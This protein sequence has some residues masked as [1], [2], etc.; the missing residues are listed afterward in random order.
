MFTLLLFCQ[1]YSARTDLGISTA[2][3]IALPRGRGIGRNTVKRRFWTPVKVEKI[4]IQRRLTHPGSCRKNC[5]ANSTLTVYLRSNALM[6]FRDV[7]MAHGATR[8]RRVF[9]PLQ[10]AHLGVFVLK[11]AITTHLS[12]I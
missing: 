9:L 2:T 3:S 1:L 10:P 4:P 8:L 6:P 7:C 11:D 5:F 12:S